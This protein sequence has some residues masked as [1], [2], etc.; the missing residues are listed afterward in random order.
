MIYL[1]TT[2]S[3]Y[4]YHFFYYNTNIYCIT[5]KTYDDG[6]DYK[7]YWITNENCRVRV[8]VDCFEAELPENLITDRMASKESVL[9]RKEQII[10]EQL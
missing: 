3:A 2:I 5:S 1:F 9:L 4:T 6:S 8:E 10:F 7:S